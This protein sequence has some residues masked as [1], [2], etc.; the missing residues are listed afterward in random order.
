M[1]FHSNYKKRRGSSN[2]SLQL[3]PKRDNPLKFPEG[4]NKK[5]AEAHDTIQYG[6]YFKNR[7]I[8]K[9]FIFLRQ[10]SI[11]GDKNI[12]TTKKSNERKETGIITRLDHTHTHRKNS[13]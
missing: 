4:N 6:K 7:E 3:R 9:Q 1:F 10:M 2:A 8:S 11:V 12:K 5:V 13:T